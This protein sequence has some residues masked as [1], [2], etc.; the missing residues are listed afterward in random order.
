MNTVVELRRL[1][2]GVATLLAGALPLSLPLSSV[3][4]QAKAKAA[5]ERVSLVVR[6]HV[7]DTLW[8]RLEQTMETRSVPLSESRR[9]SNTGSISP[10]PPAARGPEYGP[11]RDPSIS[12]TT[13]M[14]LNAHSMVESSD[15]KVT[16]LSAYTDSLFVRT[17]TGGQIGPERPVSLSASD[18]RTRV[19]VSPDGAMNIVDARANGAAVAAGLSG[20]PPMLPS[21]S[22]AVGEVWERDITLPSL[23]IAG[24][25]A[26]GIVHVRFRLD[27]LTRAGRLAFV[28]LEGTLKREGAGRDLPAGTQLATSGVLKGFLIL[29]RTRGWITDAETVIQV[30]SDIIPGAADESRARSVDIRLRQTVKVR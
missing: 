29:D 11:V 17:G 23:P 1:T 30:Q 4:A 26:E 16:W 2:L 9:R 3:G 10:R 12:R 25:R 24:L 13:L 22:V 18:R 5:P 20:M 8:L 21:K 15:L 6:P 14:R 19:N 7:G 28:S 27:S